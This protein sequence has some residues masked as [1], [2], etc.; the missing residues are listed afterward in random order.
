MIGHYGHKTH[1]RTLNWNA[2][3]IM[4]AWR[5]QCGS[6]NSSLFPVCLFGLCLCLLYW[7]CCWHLEM[8]ASFFEVSKVHPSILLRR[9]EPTFILFSILISPVSIPQTPIVIS[10]HFSSW[11]WC[12]EKSVNPLQT[13]SDWIFPFCLHFPK[14]VANRLV[15]TITF[16]HIHHLRGVWY[17]ES[18]FL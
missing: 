2:T 7:H 12:W 3:A 17:P 9:G 15:S 10:I 14:R 1:T 16:L 5:S 4:P 18:P 11:S 8:K 13:D 6:I